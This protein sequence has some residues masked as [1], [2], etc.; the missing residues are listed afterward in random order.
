MQVEQIN[1]LYDIYDMIL[2]DIERMLAAIGI[3]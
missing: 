1:A 2:V 3:K